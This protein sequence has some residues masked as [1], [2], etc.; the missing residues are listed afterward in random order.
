M[1]PCFKKKIYNDK[2]NNKK[3]RSYGFIGKIADILLIAT[4]LFLVGL[5][6]KMLITGEFIYRTGK[7]ASENEVLL[8][9]IFNIAFGITFLFYLIKGMILK[10]N[11]NDNDSEDEVMSEKEQV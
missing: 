9:A 10:W 7:V 2:F 4:G 1:Y 6:I 5:G 11:K 8:I 3:I